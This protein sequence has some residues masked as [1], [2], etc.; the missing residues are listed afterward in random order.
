MLRTILIAA[1][2][3]AVIEIGAQT[4]PPAPPA[5]PAIPATPAI[6]ASPVIP[7]PAEVGDRISP[8]AP[9]GEFDHLYRDSF[10]HALRAEEVRRAADEARRAMETGRFEIR[11][12]AEEMRRLTREA[13]EEARHSIERDREYLEH[14]RRLTQHDREAF[15][16]DRHGD[17]MHLPTPAALAPLPPLPPFPPDSWSE[18]LRRLESPTPALRPFEAPLA[19]RRGSPEIMPREPWLPQ[20]PADSIYRAARELLSRS[21]YRSAAETFRLLSQK[22]PTSGYAPDGMYYEAFALDRIGG[23]NELRAALDILERQKARFPRHDNPD[24]GLATR[25][26]GELATRGD[27][28]AAAAVASAASAQGQSCNREEM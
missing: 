11:L 14:A 9:R 18:A 7:R 25:I 22:Y 12:E 2:S 6:P 8:R 3:A 20:D 28:T 23:Q 13:A 26:Q 16:L 5:P 19:A 1:M 21:S 24:P 10:E 17:P 15:L 4:P 27:R